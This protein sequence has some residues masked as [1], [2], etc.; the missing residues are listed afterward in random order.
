MVSWLLLH[1]MNSHT[2]VADERRREL[3]SLDRRTDSKELGD[4]D[5]ANGPGF[6]AKKKNISYGCFQARDYPAREAALHVLALYC[7]RMV[8]TNAAIKRFIY[9]NPGPSAAS[10]ILFTTS[11]VRFVT[12]PPAP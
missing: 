4:G 1:L 2:G 12:P 8:P 7:S 11:I 9:S 10:S 3:Q 6:D 5:A